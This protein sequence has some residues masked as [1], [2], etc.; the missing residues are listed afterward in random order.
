MDKTE[1]IEETVAYYSEDTSRRS[2]ETGGGCFYNYNGKMCAVGR[3]LIP[4]MNPEYNDNGGDCLVFSFDMLSRGGGLERELIRDK[5]SLFKEE[6][7][8]HEEGFWMDLQELHDKP[9]YWDEN[10]LTIQGQEFV[11]KL[12]Q[13]Y[14][15]K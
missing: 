3:C 10:G 12:K 14:E 15:S 2:I 5:D 8:G 4:E 9:I 7:R 11:D 13:K 6:Y 1:I